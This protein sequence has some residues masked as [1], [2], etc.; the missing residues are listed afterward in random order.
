MFAKYWQPGT[1]KTR[2]A[3]TIGRGPA[4]ELYRGFLMAS[5]QRLRQAGDRRTLVYTPPDRQTEFAALAGSQWTLQPQASGDLGRRMRQFLESAPR[6]GADRVV[7]I[8]SDSPT[9]PPA[10]VDEAF[11]RLGRYAVVLGPSSDGG[12]YLIGVS[13]A[14]PP[15][16]SHVAWGTRRVWDQT[17]ERLRQAGWSFGVLPEWYDVDDIDSLRRMREELVH[18]GDLDAPLQEL[19]DLVHRVVDTRRLAGDADASRGDE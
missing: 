7:L 1:V 8:G 5:L 6:A 3:A 4:S 11:E 16:F 18:G 9:L 19:R 17:I 13:G 10:W 15:V 12:Y 14:V 2:L